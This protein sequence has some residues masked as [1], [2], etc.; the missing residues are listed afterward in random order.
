MSTQDGQKSCPHC[1]SANAQSASKIS[2]MLSPAQIQLLGYADALDGPDLVQSLKLLHNITV[3]HSSE[4]LDEAEKD[5]LYSIKV[6]W[7]C[8]ERIIGDGGEG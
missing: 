5:A 8:I 3:Y 6:L 1:S 4:P 2:Q 7:E